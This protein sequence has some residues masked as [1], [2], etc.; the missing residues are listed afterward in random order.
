[1]SVAEKVAKVRRQLISPS[2]TW[3]ELLAAGL[4][5]R[6][7]AALLRIQLASSPPSTGQ[8]NMRA[9]A[10]AF[11]KSALSNLQ[12]AA[13]KADGVGFADVGSS[14]L[15]CHLELIRFCDSCLLEAA[16]NQQP[17]QFRAALRA[18][19][20]D[21]VT[22]A[23]RCGSQE[24]SIRFPRL[25]CLLGESA[26]D[27]ASQNPADESLSSRFSRQMA[28]VP[29]WL[30]LPWLPQ[31]VSLLDKPDQGG[32]AVLPLLESVCDIYPAALVYPFRLARANYRFETGDSGARQAAERLWQ[33]LRRLPLVEEFIAQ[34][35]SDKKTR[36]SLRLRQVCLPA[37]T[38][39]DWLSSAKRS[40]GQ[41]ERLR[42]LHAEAIDQLF[43]DPDGPQAGSHG[44]L[45]REFAARHRRE[46]LA[47]L[48]TADRLVGI[49]SEA[50]LQRA[51]GKLWKRVRDERDSSSVATAGLA[52]FSTWLAEFAATEH[53]DAYL[54]CRDS[55]TASL[56]KPQPEL[57]TRIAGFG[58]TVR[59][60]SSLRRPHRLTIRGNDQRD[61]PY[62]RDIQCRLRRLS[63]VTYQVVPLSPDLG[64]LEW[65]ERTQPYKDFLVH[66]MSAAEQRSHSKQS[67]DYCKFVSND[68]CKLY[69]L[70]DQQVV[71][72]NF[73]PL[74]DCVPD[75]LLAR[76][77]RQLSSSWEAY[78][79]M[80]DTLVRSHAA[81]CGAHWLLSVG[82]RH[83]SNYMLCLDSAGA[84]PADK[85]DLRRHGAA[86]PS[87]GAFV[88]CLGHCLA[89]LR[90][91]R[92]LVLSVLQVF[93]NDVSA[94]WKQLAGMLT[95][96][97]RDAWDTSEHRAGSKSASASSAA[98][99]GSGSI[100][101][102]SCPE[103]WFSTEKLQ[104][105]RQKTVRRASLPD[106]E[107]GAAV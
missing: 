38:A 18:Q 13:S 74:L 73:Q 39:L 11:D 22:S 7:S 86:A 67:L 53:G 16:P 103:R 41:T 29:V 92:E 12:S 59:V 81:M 75:C 80:R 97:H 48:P 69:T 24:A 50:E 51:V 57:H 72:R 106:T 37:C 91:E 5:D 52:D 4:C 85:A 89:A 27:E 47:A 100:A 14:S 25:L 102:F 94:D 40:I 43:F 83:M 54:E 42:E 76:G 99:G 21:S 2:P 65:L 71:Q 61:R 88:R 20:V 26:D 17:Q 19:A 56:A 87:Q 32:S 23:M 33:R 34:M 31:L 44:R 98:A 15:Q 93:I 30:S 79:A 63:L 96:A 49:R 35:E 90:R 82:D 46:F 107:V 45:R 64:I 1:M 60:M 70:S 28:S 9:E 8:A 68:H 6:A 66:Q 78:Y 84:V 105:V 10:E 95:A 58:D 62:L 77:L 36:L 3:E 101:S 55:L 104:V